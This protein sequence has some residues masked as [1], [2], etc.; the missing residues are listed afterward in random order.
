MII[1]ICSKFFGTKS[2]VRYAPAGRA[3]LL[4]Y[5]PILYCSLLKDAFLL[6]AGPSREGGTSLHY[7]I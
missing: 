4:H 5:A 1:Q 7:N 2:A 6:C 3:A